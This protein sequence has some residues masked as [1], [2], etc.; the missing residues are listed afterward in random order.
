MEALHTHSLHSCSHKDPAGE[1][2]RVES[3]SVGRAGQLGALGFC[4]LRLFQAP[5]GILDIGG[6]EVQH[7]RKRECYGCVALRRLSHGDTETILYA[8]TEE[9]E[10]VYKIGYMCEPRADPDS[11]AVANMLI[12]A[13]PAVAD[14]T[15]PVEKEKLT[16]LAYRLSRA[17]IGSELADTFQFPKTRVLGTLFSFRM[18]QHL[19][20][21]AK[22]QQ[23][24]RSESFSQLLKISV[25]DEGGL[26]YKM[27]DHVHTSQSSP[28]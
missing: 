26:S 7:G 10:K 19:A 6:G 23:I 2:R 12:K 24:V 3:R 16:D 17:L 27:P 5:V 22:S 11:I 1:I 21:F 13:I 20:R 28:W 18:K 9:A 14:I 8:N 25:Y 4:H 15:D